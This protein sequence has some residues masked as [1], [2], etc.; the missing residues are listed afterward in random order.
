MCSLYAIFAIGAASYNKH[1]VQS[2]QPSRTQFPEDT[3]TSTDYISLA[4]QLIPTVYDEADI[5][6]IRGLA[7]MVGAPEKL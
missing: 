4:K 2:P 7:I 6:S 1:G 5:D 3:K